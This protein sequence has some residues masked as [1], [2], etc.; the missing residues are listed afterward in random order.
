MHPDEAIK[1]L[2]SELEKSFT[3][4]DNMKPTVHEPYMDGPNHVILLSDQTDSR[5]WIKFT[6]SPEM[7][8]EAVRD[9]P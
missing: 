2:I 5:K 7:L 9:L 6:I 3:P 1:K 8:A 4:D